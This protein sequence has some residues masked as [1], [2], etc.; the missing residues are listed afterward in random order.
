[1][2]VDLLLGRK[3]TTFRQPP[4]YL[5]AITVDHSLWNSADL[6]DHVEQDTFRLQP[7]HFVLAH[8]LERISIPDDLV[9]LVEGRSSWARVGVSIHVTAPKIDPGFDATITLEMF[10]FGKIAV[11]L[12]AGI[13]KPAQLM[14]LSV[15]TPLAEQDLYGRGEHDRFQ[16]QDSPLPRKK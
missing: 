3:F 9:G 15:S 11:E 12:R 16:H 10:N 2:S 7:G 13:D 6:W 4:A 8:T 14:F 5:P 1:V